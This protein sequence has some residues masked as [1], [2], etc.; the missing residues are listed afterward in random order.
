[1]DRLAGNG[2]TYS[3]WHKT[4]PCGPTRSCFLTAAIITRTRSRRLP[5]RPL[6]F[7]QQ[8]AHPDGERVSGRGDARETAGR[9]TGWART[10]T[11]RSMSSTW[12]TYNWYPSL[13]ED[14]HYIDQ[15]YLLEEGYHP[16]K[17]LADR[18]LEMIRTGKASQPDKPWYMFFCPG[19]NHAPHHAPREFI[20]KY[21][22]KADDG[23]E[24]YREWVLPRMIDRGI[25]PQGTQLTPMNPMS[26]ETAAPGDAVR[27]WDSLSDDEKRLFC[28]M[29]EVYA[30]FSEYTDHQVGRIVDYLE[31]TGQLENTLIFY[32]AD[33]GASG[34]GSP[35]GSVNENKFFNE[36]PDEISENLALLDQLGSPDTYNHYPTGWAMGSRPHFGRSSATAT[37]AASA[38][39]SSFIGPRG[40]GRGARCAAS[41]TIAPTSSTPAMRPPR[42]RRS[43]SRCWARAASGTTDA[44][45]SPSMR[46]CRPTRATSTRTA[47]S[48][49]IPTRTAQRRSTCPTS[50][51]RRSRSSSSSGSRRPRGSTCCRCATLGCWTTSATNSTRRF[52]G[53]ANFHGVSYKIL[54]EVKI[55]DA[56]AQGVIMAQGSR[57]GGH[58]LFIK[59]RKLHYISNFIGL[60]PEHH[61]ESE[62]WSPGPTCSEWSS[63]RKRWASAMSH[64][65]RPLLP[66]RRGK[67]A[68]LRR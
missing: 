56:S 1:M 14:N 2:L 52:Q 38:I 23:Y 6:V 12:A 19:A 5:R 58:A 20:D 65:D 15:P 55:S 40:S 22:G 37:R 66:V 59:A 43:T 44:R 62:P 8:H 35:N 27:P 26:S 39:R 63:S 46:R 57:F 50:N 41:I 4:A 49:F 13:V 67:A 10:T 16:A 32:C 31:Q 42:R 11:S 68:R 33:N 34:E 60:R 7:G 30:G 9:P 47:G 17:D 29:A 45:P 53:A 64:A 25:L 54:A 61:L 48:C 21:K 28:R 18:A 3:Q 36:W 51:P 24:A